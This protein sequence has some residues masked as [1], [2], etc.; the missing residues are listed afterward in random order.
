MTDRLIKQRLQQR[1]VDAM[2][3]V[4]HLTEKGEGYFGSRM[5]AWGH[6]TKSL[7]DITRG[8]AID[9]ARQPNLRL[10]RRS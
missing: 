5:T 8:A 6:R 3:D 9:R 4:L 7:R 10:Y 2:A 1:G